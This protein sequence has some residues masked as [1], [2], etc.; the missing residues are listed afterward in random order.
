MTSPIAP[1]TQIQLYHAP[2]RVGLAVRIAV[3]GVLTIY[4]VQ[5]FLGDLVGGLVAA[6][7]GYLVVTLELVVVARASKISL[8]VRGAP[9]RFFIAAVLI[10][11]ACWYVDLRLV[12]AIEPPGDTKK[13]EAAVS[14]AS[15]FGA[16]VAVGVLPAIGEELLFRGVVA[17]SLASRHAVLAIGASAIVFSAYHLDPVQI[18]GTFPLALALGTLAVRSGSTL[19]GMLAHF[20]N[21]AVVIVLVHVDAPGV[22]S[23]IDQHP[24]GVLLTALA[25][26]IAGVGLA[27]ARGGA[28]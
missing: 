2:P 7:I 18:V 5:L 11:V 9:A 1:R 27:A 14:H 15:L 16:L 10:G 21:N 8:G 12:S 26:V 22:V 19:P 28:A 6:A 13:L 4:V 17:R 3:A 25:M 20:L 23:V 24:T